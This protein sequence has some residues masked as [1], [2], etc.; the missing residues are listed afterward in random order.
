MVSFFIIYSKLLT[1]ALSGSISAFLHIHTTHVTAQSKRIFLCSNR[2]GAKKNDAILTLGVEEAAALSCHDE[3]VQVT[4]KP[5]WLK[6]LI[7]MRAIETGE[8]KV[9]MYYM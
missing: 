8:F 6:S 7:N 1:F 4:T 5:L 9:P 3:Q 2:E